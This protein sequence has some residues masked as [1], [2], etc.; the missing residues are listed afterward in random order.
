MKK[1]LLWGTASLLV[2]VGGGALLHWV[3]FAEPSPPA[4]LHP[5]VGDTFESTWEGV[6]QTVQKHEEGRLFV[7]VQVA[8]GAAGPPEHI[9]LGFDET[10]TV[11][12]GTLTVLVDGETQLLGPGQ[13]VPVPAG[14]AHTF[15]NETDEPVVGTGWLPEEFAFFLS[16]MYG[17]IDEAEANSRSPR[18]VL[19]M[20]LFQ[21]RCEA[22]AHSCDGHRTGLPDREG[23][24]ES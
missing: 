23:R 14:T 24:R 2:Y 15:R 12:S 17:F 10:L 1:I 8:P 5:T 9:H 13:S 6:R 19:Q 7:E 20:A 11:Q 18:I 22:A 4:H 3:I 16:Q 21:L